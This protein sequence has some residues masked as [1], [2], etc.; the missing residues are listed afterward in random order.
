M[1]RKAHYLMIGLA[2]LALLM[3]SCRRLPFAEPTS[4]PTVTPT[5]RSTPLPPVPTA[6]PLGSES[7]PL[8]LK[9]SRAANGTLT[10]H[11]G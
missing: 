5:P 9:I 6:V 8:Q 7:N 3:T 2:C 1:N 4:R 10:E 11:S